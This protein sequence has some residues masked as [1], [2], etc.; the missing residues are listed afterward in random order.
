[1]QCL[2]PISFCYQRV[3]TYAACNFALETPPLSSLYFYAPLSVNAFQEIRSDIV[4]LSFSIC[5]VT[6]ASQRR[7]IIS[8][9]VRALQF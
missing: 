5:D 9:V 4:A 1:M 7:N 8:H 2:W 6:Y 3:L